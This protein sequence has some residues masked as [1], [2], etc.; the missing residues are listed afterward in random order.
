[1]VEF[2]EYR[3]RPAADTV[4][5]PVGAA[6]SGEQVIA[7]YVSEEDLS[8]MGGFLEGVRK[9]EDRPISLAEAVDIVE[10]LE[11]I[12]VK[13]DEELGHFLIAKGFSHVLGDEAGCRADGEQ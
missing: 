6:K 13:V 4:N 2:L 1:V 3:T 5:V 12:E 9:K 11:V 7:A 10:D 8:S